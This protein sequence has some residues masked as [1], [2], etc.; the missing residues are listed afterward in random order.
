[1]DWLQG[2]SLYADL[3]Q[4]PWLPEFAGIAT[5]DDLSRADCV[6]LAR[7]EGF[8]GRLGFDGRHFE[9]LRHIDFQPVSPTAD[10]GSLHWEAQILVERGRDVDY[11]E[12]WHREA[13][14]SA[15]WA[16]TLLRETDRGTAALLVRAGALF[17]F[18]RD[19]AD[20]LVGH[21]TLS[22]AVAAAPDVR[23]ARAMIDCEISSGAVTA[24]GFRITASTLPYRVGRRLGQRLSPSTMT[25]PD[26][27][28]DGGGLERRWHI[29]D[30]E[31]DTAA[32]R[33]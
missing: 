7:Q 13:G 22:D 5:L 8:A 23:A 15:P 14:G 19:R 27:D 32:L 26:H 17:M 11:L 3:R 20:P 28:A 10:A 33:A 25:I 12:H 29:V 9:W 1:V 6:A 24:H 4:P 16:A 18:A 21:R 31:G 30:A 2:V